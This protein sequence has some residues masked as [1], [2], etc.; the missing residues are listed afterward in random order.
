MLRYF[1]PVTVAFALGC[2]VCAETH[3]ELA[4]ER[5][6]QMD[7]LATNLVSVT[8]KA[9]AEKAVVELRSIKEKMTDIRMRGKVLGKPAPDVDAA[10]KT[11]MA[12]KGA[13]LTK[14]LEELPKV[15]EKAEPE[16]MVIFQKGL[17]EFQAMVPPA[18]G[19]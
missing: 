4:D 13:E 3:K 18:K 8:D 9:S 11:K 10:L 12:A 15:L 19:Q 16:A 7:R 14:R 17:Q 1:L 6:V 5:I 2:A